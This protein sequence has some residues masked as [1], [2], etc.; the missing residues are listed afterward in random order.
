MICLLG[1]RRLTR[2]DTFHSCRMVPFCMMGPIFYHLFTTLPNKKK[3]KI[4]EST[5]LEAYRYAEDK[6][7][8][9]LMM[10]AILD[11]RVEIMTGL[12]EN[13]CYQHFSSFCKDFSVWV[14]REHFIPHKV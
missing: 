10:F 1:L 6:L 14:A 7:D 2:V 9:A 8:E 11:D 12:G 4:G 3:K 5:K 13:A